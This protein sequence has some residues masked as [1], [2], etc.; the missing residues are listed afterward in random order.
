MTPAQRQRDDY[1]RELLYLRNAGSAFARAHP[2]VA[3]R[4]ELSADQSPDPHVERLL[5]GFAFLAARLGRRIDDSVS[6]LAANLL[7]QLCPHATRPLPSASV[8]C[9]EPDPAKVDVA[10]GYAVARG[11]ALFADT[12]DG[13]SIYFRTTAPLVLW[14]LRVCGVDLLTDGLEALSGHSGRRSVL[15]VRLACPASFLPRASRLGTLRFYVKGGGDNAARLCDL[16]YAHTLEVRWRTP[17]AEPVTLAGA[18]PR[19]AGLEP[20][21]ALLP[22]QQDTHPG[23]RLLLEYF[24]FPLKFQFFDL[25]CSALGAPDALPGTAG[26][27]SY[28]L[29]FVLGA[30]PG[31][32][33]EPEADALQLGCAPVVN[34]FPRTS[35]P[36]RIT[37]TASQYK[38][39]P[40]NFRERSTEIYSIEQIAS[41]VP[42]EPAQ[43]VAPYFA[44]HGV[45]GGAPATYWHAQ[46]APAAKPGLAGSD[47]LLSFVDP[48]FDPATPAARTLVA[49]LQCTSR[50][51]A[52]A[53]AAGT[54]LL[55]ED[56]GAIARIALLHKPSAQSQS[57]PDGS[58]R[59]KLVSQLSLNHLSLVEGESALA[60][61]KEL[62][63]LN[64][65][66][67][68]V[69]ADAQIDALAKLACERVTRYVNNDPWHGYRHG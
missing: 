52:E 46:R 54:P 44:W 8:A 33:L 53:L 31:M 48:A 64:N 26:S 49:R 3:A 4:L 40:D 30:R 58:A 2:T 65:L 6:A 69:V 20:D 13:A 43:P 28:E 36:V 60:T 56:A 10:G 15:S 57:A 7:E 22:A 68:A 27:T 9:F 61:L 47:M 21:D 41:S 23:L 63:V 32:P 51:L 5:E 62:L 55:M 34:L 12:A 38:L 29:L 1:E 39:V 17:G 18:L 14:P 42:G 67:G 16:L 66:G 37:G 45:G 11:S 50:G 24:A 19:F 25:D 35:E 59:W